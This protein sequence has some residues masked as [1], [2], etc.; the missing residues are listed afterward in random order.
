MININ[1]WGKKMRL[2]RVQQQIVDM[3]KTRNLL[4]SDVTKLYAGNKKKA[5]GELMKLIHNGFLIKR[6]IRHTWFYTKD[7]KN[8]T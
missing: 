6:M 4:L 3:A 2:G 5:Q 8:E 7:I 1:Q